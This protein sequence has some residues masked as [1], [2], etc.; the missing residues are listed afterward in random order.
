MINKTNSPAYQTVNKDRRS[1]ATTKTSNIELQ[2][3]LDE[4]GRLSNRIDTV[5][6]T[7]QQR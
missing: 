6:D 7:E 4:L 2:Q 1:S 3:S 5:V